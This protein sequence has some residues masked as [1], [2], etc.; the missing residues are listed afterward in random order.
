MRRFRVAALIPLALCACGR[1]DDAAAPV[2]QPSVQMSAEDRQLVATGM[3]PEAISAA[4]AYLMAF[5][6]ADQMACFGEV[7]ATGAEME[8]PLMAGFSA[9]LGVKRVVVAIDGSGSMAAPVGGRSKL[10]LAKEATLSFIDSL[11]SDV[12]ASLLVLGQQGDNSGAGKAISCRGID[13]A[14][15]M[16]RDRATLRQSVKSVRAVGWTPLAAALQRAQELLSASP[17]GRQVVYVVSDGNETCGG[18]PIAIARAINNGNTRAI[19][20]II[21]FDLPR[22]DRAALGAVARAGGGA[23]ID[24]RDDASYQRML[25]ATR[26]AMRRSNNTVRA[27]NARAHNV[28][29]AGAA[30]T[31]ATIC[32]GDIITRETLAVGGDLTRRVVAKQVSPERHV[33]FA[34]LEQRHKAMRAKREEFSARVKG[35]RDQSIT[36]IDAQEKVAR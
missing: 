7:A 6:R 10:E 33:V 28:I 2:D 26:E 22:A 24:I 13:Q 5:T 15:P 12:E 11:G 27:S 30:I 36:T 32:T 18:D 21:G 23:L 34:V 16:S 14:A 19:V 31:K 20:N 3:T 4:H 8:A 1:Q 25:A 29:D 35:A 17:P 9:T